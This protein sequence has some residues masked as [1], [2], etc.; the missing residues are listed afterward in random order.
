MTYSERIKS[1]DAIWDSARQGHARDALPPEKVLEG[2]I[3]SESSLY[4]LVYFYGRA[5][6]TAQLIDKLVQHCKACNWDKNVIKIKAEDIFTILCSNVKRHSS[7]PILTEEELRVLGLFILEDI[8]TIA[9]RQVLEELVY[10]L[11]DQLLERH[12]RIVVTGKVSLLEMERLAPRIRT[13]LGG[14]IC[15]CVG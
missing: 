7:M 9:G 4:D 14:G 10:G 12:V 13:Q 11:L 8:D 2:L 6:D 3:E 5:K 15:C 1:D